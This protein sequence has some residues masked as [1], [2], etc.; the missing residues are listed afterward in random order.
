[1]LLLSVTSGES[2]IEIVGRSG[3][4]DIDIWRV[5]ITMRWRG[6]MNGR[7]MWHVMKMVRLS[8]LIVWGVDRQKLWDEIDAISD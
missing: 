1:M 3:L 2:D 6:M 7:H 4:A 8:L 5:G